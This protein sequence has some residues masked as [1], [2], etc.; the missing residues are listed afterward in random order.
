MALSG[1][2]VV[3]S[4]EFFGSNDFIFNSQKPPPTRTTSISDLL[5]VIQKGVR[6]LTISL[7][8]KGV[9]THDTA[10]LLPLI[11]DERIQIQRRDLLCATQSLHDLLLGPEG[12][13]ESIHVCMVFMS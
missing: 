10:K 6:G 9:S 13:L 2:L 12:I 5:D 1:T 4:N 3:G 11:K 7:S 8:E